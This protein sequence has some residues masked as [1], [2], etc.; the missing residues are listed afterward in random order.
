MTVPTLCIDVDAS[1]VYQTKR[2]PGALE[3]LVDL[4]RKQSLDMDI[5]IVGRSFGVI[6]PLKVAYSRS[7][8]VNSYLMISNIIDAEPNFSQIH[9]GITY[10]PSPKS[11]HNIQPRTAGILSALKFFGRQYKTFQCLWG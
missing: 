8:G 11:V 2:W 1:N 4:L 9:G 10:L 5:E 6:Q 3:D 7:C